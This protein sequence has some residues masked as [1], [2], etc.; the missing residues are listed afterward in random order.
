MKK[1]VPIS[2]DVYKRLEMLEGISHLNEARMRRVMQKTACIPK[3]KTATKSI[4]DIQARVQYSAL[5]DRVWALE[6][7]VALLKPTQ[8][9]ERS[10]WQRYLDWMRTE[11]PPIAVLITAILALA[12][13]G[14]AWVVTLTR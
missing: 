6:N 3:A 10:L 12:A 4:E 5:A 8:A 11:A 2:G 7:E 13:A 1:S 14:M 9:I